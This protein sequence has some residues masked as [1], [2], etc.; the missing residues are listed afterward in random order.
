MTEHVLNNTLE[1]IDGRLDE[2]EQS[3]VEQRLRFLIEAGSILA[4]SLDYV[5]TLT[6][7]V[8]LIVPRLADWCV[9]DI[10][11]DMGAIRRIAMKHH[12]PEKTPLLQTL[13][14]SF[15]HT[16]DAPA[17]PA[18]VI[19]TGLSEH[20]PEVSPASIA[21]AARNQ[22]HLDLLIALDMRS[23]MCVP[24][25]ARGRS[26][27][28][29]S[30]VQSDSD[31]RYQATDLTLAEELGRRA[32]VAVDN[33]MLFEAE[34][35]SRTRAEATQ[36][37]LAFLADA[38]GILTASLDYD[39]VVNRL[40]ELTV[41]LLADLCVIDTLED[42]N[43]VVRAAI[44]H[45]DPER[46]A[47][48][49]ELEL[50]YP[51]IL[52]SSRTLRQVLATLEPVVYS[53]LPPEM[54]VA[55]IPSATIRERTGMAQIRASM[56]VPIVARGRAIGVLSLLS[57]QADRYHTA[58]IELAGELASRA[59]I[60]IENAHLYRGSQA[61]REQNQRAAERLTVLAEASRAFTMTQPDSQAILDAVAREVALRIGDL[62]IIRLL[63]PDGEY[64]IPASVYS[65]DPREI[66]VTQEVLH[67]NRHHVSE[68]LNG[69][70]V[71]TGEPIL[72]SETSVDALTPLVKTEYRAHLE[73]FRTTSLLIVPLSL[74]GR[75]IGTMGV[76]R[77][78][79]DVPYSSDDFALIQDLAER[80][81]LAVESAR[82][83]E[84][85]Q[86]AEVRYRSLFESVADAIL[87]ADGDGRY[88]DAN[89]A[90]IRLLGFSCD[91]I[92]TMHVGDLVV[93]GPDWAEAEYE[94][95]L[96]QGF[97]HG[98]V[99]LRRKDGT[100][101]PVESTATIAELPS[102]TV[103][104]ASMRD[105]TERRA[106]EIM[107]RDFIAMVTHDLKSPLTS[108]RGFAQLMQRREA[109]SARGAE[110]IIAQ[111]QQLERLI[112][113]LLDAAR[114][115]AGHADLRRSRF[116]LV[117]LTE[118]VAEGLQA[119]SALHH[120]RVEAA[121]S[122][123]PGK[124]DHD[125]LAQILQNLLSNAVKYAPNGGEILVSVGIDDTDAIIAVADHG[126]GIPETALPHIFDRFYRVDGSGSAKGLGLGLYITHSLV[127]A[128]GGDISVTST[129]GSGSTFTVR[130]PTDD[131]S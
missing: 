62:C 107:Q 46:A 97:W 53:E 72:L 120:I 80:A 108:I 82:L 117:D 25:I 91:E 37:Q 60:A 14:K 17:G 129:K 127:K 43:R 48:I 75:V 90:A 40:A 36:Q 57:L 16:P 52:Q 38:S 29:I 88:Q 79:P 8:N 66:E 95:Y 81:A 100:F 92:L 12:D 54:T 84:D 13:E 114:F 61:A 89:P 85:A 74:R 20:Y 15:P 65:P 130:L 24:L 58:E 103:Y 106:A 119:I 1:G 50:E 122:S 45:V 41:P 31:R 76:S 113:D 26:V 70:V 27:G 118:S 55:A 77:T 94:A 47:A 111:T 23:Y 11:D 3:H 42:D 124:W 104:L 101:V 68:G 128:H 131:V 44:A 109:Y 93:N 9:V 4:A 125:R 96:S 64:L 112:T 34:R 59:A 7:V 69:Q 67:S 102:G 30:F 22:T 19:R 28:A 32:A 71:S 73:Q 110:A 115:E 83:L 56:S 49:R 39:T 18:S 6:S 123:I 105:I 35:A 78:R 2:S 99:D 5:T 121:Q 33:A 10:V 86:A 98:E 116:D 87:V 21:A 126:S 51:E 63:S